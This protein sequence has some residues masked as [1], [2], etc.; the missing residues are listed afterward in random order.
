MGKFGISITKISTNGILFILLEAN[1]KT[2]IMIWC[3]KSEFFA[4]LRVV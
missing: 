3:G 4:Q 2:S 1:L